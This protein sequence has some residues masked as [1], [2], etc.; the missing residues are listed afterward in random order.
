MN[1]HCIDEGRDRDKN[2]NNK[3]SAVLDTIM[4]EMT[5]ARHIPQIRIRKLKMQY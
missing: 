2:D 3:G 1:E 4:D 5:L